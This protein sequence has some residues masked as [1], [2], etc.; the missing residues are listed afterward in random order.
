VQWLQQHAVRALQGDHP[1]WVFIRGYAS[2]KYDANFNL[3]LSKLRAQRVRDFLTGAGVAAD[4]I[5]GIE[6]VGE[7]WSTGGPADNSYRWR[8][9]EVIVTPRPEPRPSVI[10]ILPPIDIHGRIVRARPRFRIRMQFSMSAGPLNSVAFIIHDRSRRT[11]GRF[12]MDGLGWGPSVYPGNV[13]AAGTWFDIPEDPQLTGLHDFRWA[14]VTYMGTAPKGDHQG[15]PGISLLRIRPAN[16][17]ARMITFRDFDMGE[18]V[19]PGDDIGMSAG[20]LRQMPPTDVRE[21]TFL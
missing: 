11:E 9:V 14:R 15:V 12:V 3:G 8:C 7:E 1:G 2:R 18:S 20:D 5:T 17:Q 6:G 4:R 10:I 16:P 19:L 13:S 21:G